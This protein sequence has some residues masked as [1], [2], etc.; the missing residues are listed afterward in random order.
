MRLLL[1]TCLVFLSTFLTYGQGIDSL[2]LAGT[3]LSDNEPIPFAKIHLEETNQTQITGIE[4]DFTFSN[5]APGRYRLIVRIQG[6][7]DVTFDVDHPQQEL[8][9]NIPK[10]QMI[11]KVVVTGTRTDRR[12]TDSPVIVGVINSKTLEN[13]QACTLSDGLKFQSGLRVE[14]DC[15]TCNY[16][17]LRMNGLAG[18]YSQILINGRPIFSPLT[19]LYGLEQIPT[20]MIERIEVVRGGGSALFGSSAIGGTV[21]VLT[22]IPTRKMFSISNNFQ[23]INGSATDNITTGNGVLLSKNKKFGTSIFV[24]N[25]NRTYYDDNGDNF[26][27]LPKLHNYSFG[28]TLFF[29]PTTN[30]KLELS[31]SNLNEYRYGG[32]M[33]DLPAHE[34]SQ[35]EER[36]H[37]V[38]IGSLDYQINFKKTPG[39]LITY[40]AGQYTDR[41]H[42]T[43][44]LP[45]DSAGLAIH[46]ENPPYGV[47]T[48]ST[49]QGGVQYNH[50]IDNFLR[51]NNVITAGAEWV[52]DDVYD[53]ITAYDYEID[54]TTST[55]G[56]FIQSDWEITHDLTL[57]AGVRADKHNLLENVVV[58]PRMS[59]MYKIKELLQLR[60]TWGQGFRAPQAFDTD[61][62]IAFAG[63]GI[64]RITLADDLLSEQSN[65]I[66][67]SINFDKGWEKFICGFTLEGFYTEL[68]NA[69]YL[70]PLGE[71]EFGEMFEKRNG[72]GATVSGL[73]LELRANYK[74]RLEFESGFTFQSS[75]FDTPVEYSDQ[76]DRTREFLRTPNEYGYAT[77]FYTPKFPLT[78]SLNLVYTGPMTVLHLTGAPEQLQDE[79]YRSNT[80]T[81][82]NVKVGYTFTL[83]PEALSI[84]IFGGVKNLTNAYQSAFDTGKNRDSNFIYGPSLPRTFFLGL[85]LFS[86]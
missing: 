12:K 58:N 47:S 27:E 28:T 86:L 3:V 46:Y 9:L 8:A 49:F 54:Q 38:W 61:M 44:I 7:P 68:D 34:A 74:K 16:T 55:F 75:L 24:N 77:L 29:R 78:T 26:S 40:V 23:L 56:S 39:S 65:S 25:R 32:E 59:L 17:Q 69:F 37:H 62:H 35:A 45:D 82:L 20:N 13:V 21:N 42:Y 11:D 83:K 79:F 80:F 84:Q 43:G 15:Q 50:R 72:D 57:L 6:Y 36:T 31:L 48:T 63:G 52:Y 73:S 10:V 5:I 71:D 85:K 22:K 19:G 81:E 53:L 60:V 2:D 1:N 18:G 4:G 67:G 14:T 33:V 41:K 64:S 76:L 70:H 51:G 66:S 30:Q